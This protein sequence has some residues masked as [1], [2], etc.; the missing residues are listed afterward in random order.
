MIAES[1]SLELSPAVFELL[2]ARH[3]GNIHATV[4]GTPLVKGRRTDAQLSEY[5][6]YRKTRFD[7]FDRIRDLA[8][9]E[10]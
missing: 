5:V 1:T 7:S 6:R 10:F 2:H 9:G 8:V 3:H 4:L